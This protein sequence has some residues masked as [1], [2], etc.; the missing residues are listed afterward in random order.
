MVAQRRDNPRQLRDLIGI[1]ARPAVAIDTGC[2]PDRDDIRRSAVKGRDRREIEPSGHGQHPAGIPDPVRPGDPAGVELERPGL[3]PG[4]DENP[5]D[6]RGFAG[7]L[8]DRIR[9]GCG[10]GS[11]IGVGDGDPGRT[12]FAPQPGA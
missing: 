2:A 12:L 8:Q 10:S 9:I 7:C 6:P 5:D 1:E 3:G 11:L 4:V